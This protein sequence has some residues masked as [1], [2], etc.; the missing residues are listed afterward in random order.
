MVYGVNKETYSCDAFLGLPTDV[1]AREYR[2]VCYYPA[3]KQCELMVV[4]VNDTTSVSVT[5]GS[6]FGSSVTYGG[7]TYGAG[8]TLTTTIDR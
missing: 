4:G 5:F 3:S 2:V 6:V 8:D 7:S 1:M